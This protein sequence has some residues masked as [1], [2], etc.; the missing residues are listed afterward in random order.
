MVADVYIEENGFYQIDCTA[1]DW[2]TDQVQAEYHKSG[3]FL[4]DVDFV[5]CTDDFV[6]LIEYKNANAPGASKPDAFKP[7]EDSK[8][9]SVARK[10]YD[11]L[12]YLAINGISK[13]VKFIYIVEYP[14]AG[15]VERK[16]L[17]NKIAAKLPFKLQENKTA[18][19]VDDFDV[20]SISEW[21][22]HE[23]YSVFPLAQ[24]SEDAS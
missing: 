6:F 10:F 15:I 1:A 5:A 14:S 11:S 16:M 2:S 7:H 20:V 9:D 3:L 12:H 17:R 24:V 23:E 13:P 22:T 4:S 21:N 19:I 18:R 8:V